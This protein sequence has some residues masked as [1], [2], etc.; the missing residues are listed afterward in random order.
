M[1]ANKQGFGLELK[2]G[3]T[4]KGASTLVDIKGEPKYLYMC[5][6]FSLRQF[7]HNHINV[8]IWNVALRNFFKLKTCITEEV[9]EEIR[10]AR[11]F[12]AYEKFEE[13][14]ASSVRTC[15]VSNTENRKRIRKKGL[16]S[17][18]FNNNFLLLEF[19]VQLMAISDVIHS[20]AGYCL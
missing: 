1:V 9:V 6:T 13:V 8:L 7:V 14:L 12:C 4:N 15:N 20:I 5:R 18:F 3:T 19:N 11:D 10:T 2:K 16:L 17:N